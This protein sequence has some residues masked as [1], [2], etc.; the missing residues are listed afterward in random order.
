MG[1]NQYGEEEVFVVKGQARPIAMQVGTPVPGNNSVISDAWVQIGNQRVT[2]V[3]VGAEFDIYCTY[4]GVNQGGG[5]WAL[6]VTVVGVGTTIANFDIAALNPVTSYG[7]TIMTGS[8][9]KLGSKGSNI[10]PAGSGA[11]QLRFK[12]WMNDDSYITTPPPDQTQW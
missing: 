6:C 3:P 10:M 2:E 1:I 5:F 8:N 11:L 4:S 12:M 7:G 9:K